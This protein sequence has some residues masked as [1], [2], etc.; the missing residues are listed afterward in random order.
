LE[1]H[2]KV[3]YTHKVV[4]W[5]YAFFAII[6]TFIFFIPSQNTPFSTTLVF[7]AV[8]LML[9]GLFAL[10]HYTSRGALTKDKWALNSSRGLAIFMLIGFPVGTLVGIYLLINCW[11][12]WEIERGN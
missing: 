3:A 2:I 5:I 7:L 1:S 10:H 8:P 4:S 11:K 9:W 6:F 12:G